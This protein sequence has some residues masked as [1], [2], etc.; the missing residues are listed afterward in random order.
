MLLSAGVAPARREL[1]GA[2][3]AAPRASGLRGADH[4]VSGG[5][6]D[7]PVV[8]RAA[9]RCARGD[10]VSRQPALLRVREGV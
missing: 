4:S 8:R 6:H 1:Q 3:R 2:P 7:Q 5:S 9:G 10:H